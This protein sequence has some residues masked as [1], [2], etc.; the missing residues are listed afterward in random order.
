MPPDQITTSSKG[1]GGRTRK[2]GVG[3]HL[4]VGEGIQGTL[5]NQREEDI[6]I[7]DRKETHGGEEI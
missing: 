2:G 3:Y 6:A 1:K 5:G 4:S 7:Q